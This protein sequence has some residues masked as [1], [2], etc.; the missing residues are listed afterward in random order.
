MGIKIVT[1]PKK[2]YSASKN[3][4]KRLS[5][6]SGYFF[7]KKMVE[8]LTFLGGMSTKL[9][10][11]LIMGDQAVRII[12]VGARHGFHER[13]KQ[14][15]KSLRIFLFEPDLI[16][17][18]ELQ[19]IYKDD[20]RIT[21]F[22]TALSS[23]G[24]KLKIHVTASPDSSSA[25]EHEQIFFSKLDMQAFYKLDK[26]VEIDSKKLSEVMSE[27]VDFIKLDVEGFELPI[28]KGASESMIDNLIGIEAEVSYVPWAKGIP[29]FGD[30]DSFCRSKGFSLSN[31]TQPGIYHYALKDR[32]MESLGY[33]MSGDALY[34]RTPEQVLE[35]IQSGK[36]NI[37][38][39]PI[40]LAIYLAY[41]NSEF[42]YILL[43]SSVNAGII[44][45]EDKLYFDTMSLIKLRSGS[46]RLFSY[47]VVRQ[48]KR[49]FRVPMGL[50]Y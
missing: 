1:V 13:W 50:D 29:L 38:K 46:G 40:A 27:P 3:S 33:V 43:E 26:I 22:N 5:F 6:F 17:Y 12:D 7:R 32:R 36:W 30:V 23:N 10:L 2:D 19:E 37:S 31:L 39:M 47:K 28:L 45:K 35:R 14:F 24:E 15:N 20:T 4:L 41:G 48:F 18:Q 9:N 34:F 44:K 21:S 49:T 16:A 42:A 8:I 25:F 11:D